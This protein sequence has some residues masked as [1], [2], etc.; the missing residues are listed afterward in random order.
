MSRIWF[1]LITLMLLFSALGSRDTIASLDRAMVHAVGIDKSGE[2]Y[3]V[4]ASFDG[5]AGFPE[6]VEMQV[7]EIRSG[8]VA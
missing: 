1:F 6:G 3:S 7:T 4:T 8:S 2:G 5:A